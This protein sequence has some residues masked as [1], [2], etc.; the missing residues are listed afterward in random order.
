[1]TLHFVTETNHSKK[2]W[3]IKEK[4]LIFN[5][6]VDFGVQ[7]VEAGFPAASDMDF[8]AV[9]RLAE[10]APSNLVISGLA[11]AVEHDIK[12]GLKQ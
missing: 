7:A 4:E 2:P 10:I 9:K 12:K 11:R 5:K 1:M 6:L 8:D 3:N